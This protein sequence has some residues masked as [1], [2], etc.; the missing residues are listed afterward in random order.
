MTPQRRILHAPDR[1]P[2]RAVKRRPP[3]RAVKA[4]AFGLS[5]P[6]Q[7]QQG[8]AHLDLTLHG[9][10]SARADEVV[11][12]HPLGHHAK[13]QRLSGFQER[14]RQFRNSP[15]RAK[16]G[17]V[18]VKGDDGFIMH[19]PD[20]PQL[21]LGDGRSHRRNRR[22][23]PGFRQRDHVH[24]PFGNDQRRLAGRLSCRS[25]IVEAPALVEKLGL[26]RVQVLGVCV[27]I[28]CTSCKR[29]GN[30]PWITNG[31][32]DSVAEAIIWCAAVIRLRRQSRIKHEI[33]LHALAGKVREEVLPL[34]GRKADFPASQC[35]VGQASPRQVVPGG[36]P[37]ASL[38]F[39]AVMLNR[40]FHDLGKS[41]SPV[42]LPLRLRVRLRH[43]HACFASQDLDRLH[44]G[45]VLRVL[46]EPEDIAFRVAAEA[47]VETLSVVHVERCGL[48]LVKRARRPH[49][50]LALFRLAGIPGDLPAHD[51]AERG[52]G[53]QFIKE[54]GRETHGA[55][56][57]VKG[58]L[59]QNSRHTEANRIPTA[60]QGR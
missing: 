33:G 22:F 58:G 47:V 43:L 45:D 13:P 31:K 15:C 18:S 51:P 40:L 53:L 54:A 16:P 10:R 50:P 21:L 42:R 49:V 6:Q 24:V 30:S 26:R 36:D 8:K 12:I 19:L 3:L 1:G 11:G 2:Q 28:H 46:D 57:R 41:G 9:S 52:A 7:L 27:R 44:E 38:Q 48:F 59:V 39:Q 14:Q 34:V 23:E 20:K 25:M 32:D 56:I 29:N 55:N 17:L 5:P 60:G 35:L 37:R 4:L